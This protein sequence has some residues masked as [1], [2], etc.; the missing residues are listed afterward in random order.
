MVST[1]AILWA[2]EP[3]LHDIGAG[4]GAACKTCRPQSNRTAHGNLNLQRP[5]PSCSGGPLLDTF[6]P[7]QYVQMKGLISWFLHRTEGQSWWYLY[8]TYILG[9][10]CVPTSLESK[11]NA[12]SVMMAMTWILPT[13][14]VRLPAELDPMKLVRWR[15]VDFQPDAVEYTLQWI[16]VDS[17]LH[18][19]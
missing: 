14:V 1:C 13:L 11:D 16:L 3:H 8:R 17:S 12:L 9:H 15:W 10:N 4:E 6:L 18:D 19:L 7:S 2:T 5:N